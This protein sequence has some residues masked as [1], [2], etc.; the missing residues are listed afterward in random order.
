MKKFLKC[1]NIILSSEFLSDDRFIFSNSLEKRDIF[2]SILDFSKKSTRKI[3][4]LY[5]LRR[6]GKTVLLQQWLMS[7][8]SKEIKEEEKSV[9]ILMNG[10]SFDDLKADLRVLQE[11]GYRFIAIDEISMCKD[12]IDY[13]APLSDYF[14]G[15]GM[16]ILIAGT[17]SLALFF[18][19]HSSL[20]D[21]SSLFHT[22]HIS[23]AEWC[24]LTKKIDIDQY[25]P[26]GGL[27]HLEPTAD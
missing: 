2:K 6:T 8:E 25:L 4:M 27:L 21:R 11:N 17:D 12:F 10:E 22:T 24:R 9:Y 23:F 18:A 19:S 15:K 14:C 26:Y 13:A 1:K 7:M 20:F 3:G 16:K 5:G